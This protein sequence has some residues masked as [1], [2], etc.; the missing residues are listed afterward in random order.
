[1]RKN[2]PESFSSQ[3]KE[4]PDRLAVSGSHTSKIFYKE[5]ETVDVEFSDLKLK[6]EIAP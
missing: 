4:N 1:M 5:N 3:S 2:A 6:Q